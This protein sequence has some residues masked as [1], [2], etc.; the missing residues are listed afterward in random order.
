MK[1]RTFKRLLAIAL[2]SLLSACSTTGRFVVPPGSTLYLENRKEPVTVEPDGTVTTKPFGWGAIGSP[3]SRGIPYRLEKDG[4][5]I[6]EGKL[7]VSI[8]VAAF[9]WPPIYG[10]A[11]IP[12][13]F[14]DEITYDL[15][16]G[17]QE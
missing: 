6:Q 4:K 12:L 10:I 5:T 7:R 2:V 11:A 15:V 1:I 9:I 17:K 16:N 13:G 8:R 14:R 3:P